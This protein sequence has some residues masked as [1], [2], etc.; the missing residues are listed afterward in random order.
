MLS[1]ARRRFMNWWHGEDDGFDPV[2]I[3][4]RLYTY[5]RVIVL[6]LCALVCAVIMGGMLSSN[7]APHFKALFDANGHLNTGELTLCLKLV[8]SVTL[9]TCLSYFIY[10]RWLPF[11]SKVLMVAVAALILHGSVKNSAGIQARD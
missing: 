9:I 11:L 7:L 4:R 10:A 1:G 3:F 2:A 5:E 6:I 8:G